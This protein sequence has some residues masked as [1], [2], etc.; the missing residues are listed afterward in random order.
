MRLRAR[1]GRFFEKKLRKKLFEKG[2]LGGNGDGANMAVLIFEGARPVFAE[3]KDRQRLRFFGCAHL[4][5]DGMVA[6]CLEM[7]SNWDLSVRKLLK[8]R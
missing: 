8:L 2:F 4:S 7:L 1:S 5:L 6:E 3:G